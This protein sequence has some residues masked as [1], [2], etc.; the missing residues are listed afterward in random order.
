VLDEKERRA[1]I[2]R[3]EAIEILNRR[4][5]DARRL[6]HACVRDENVQSVANDTAS[7]PDQVVSPVRSSTI[8]RYYLSPPAGVANLGD[9]GF[10]F[11]LAAAI[12]NKNLCA[13]LA[14]ARALA[15]PMPREAPVTERF[16]LRDLP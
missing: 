8:R 13:S 9:D 16:Y 11:G 1:N 6:R 2:D 3:E 4:L 12:M 14:S 7:L 15:R 10:G 5:L